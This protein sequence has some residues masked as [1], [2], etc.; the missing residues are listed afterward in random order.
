MIE[1][2]KIALHQPK[3]GV[4]SGIGLLLVTLVIGLSVLPLASAFNDTL[5][6]FVISIKG[7]RIISEYIVP[8]EVKWVVVL[9][10]SLGIPA[11]AAGEYVFLPGSQRGQ[12]VEIIWNCIGWQS[13]VVFL[14]TA[15]VMLRQR[16]TLFSKLKTLVVGI[17]GTVLVNLVRITLVI[18][19]W[20][21]VSPT[22]GRVFHDYG[23]LLTNTAWLIFFWRFSD[24]FVLESNEVN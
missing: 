15:A 11:Q 14:L 16:F 1:K 18:L 12:L 19:L 10:R 21:M 8:L 6:R 20:R 9:L 7:Y 23:A 13:L 3:V 22:V 17:V 2:P 24:T 5:T 4:K